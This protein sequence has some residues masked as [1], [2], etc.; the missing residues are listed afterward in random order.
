MAARFTDRYIR[1]VGQEASLGRITFGGSQRDM[2][3]ATIG[4]RRVAV[5]GARFVVVSTSGVHRTGYWSYRSVR[6]NASQE[7]VFK[8]A[9]QGLCEN[10]INVLKLLA[11]QQSDGDSPVQSVVTGLHERSRKGTMDGLRKN[12]EIDNHSAVDVGQ[13]SEGRRPFK[14]RKP[15]FRE[16]FN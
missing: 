2:E 12:V 7:K 6:T 14:V 1:A 15:I 5:G 3:T 8:A 10:L 16:E 4:R 11:N 13:L 9:P